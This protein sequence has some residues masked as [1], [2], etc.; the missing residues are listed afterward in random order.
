MGSCIADSVGVEVSTQNKTYEW[1]YLIRFTDLKTQRNFQASVL[2]HS[3]PDVQANVS[4]MIVFGGKCA[5]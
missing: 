3:K 2:S 4:N 1:L 5:K